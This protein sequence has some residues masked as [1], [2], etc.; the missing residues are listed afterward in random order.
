MKGTKSYHHKDLK[1]ALLQ[2]AV[3]LIQDE[4]MKG[5]SMRK[6]A[7]L[8]GVSH[9][10][11]YRHFASK[12]ELLATLML[13]GHM[14]LRA[15]LLATAAATSG[16]ARDKLLAMGRAYLDF[17]REQPEYISLMFS[18]EGM[19]AAMSVASRQAEFFAED[20]DSFGPLEEAVRACQA[21]GSLDPS[22]DPGALS[23]AV[24]SQVH[25]LALLRNEGM[26]RL[27]AAERGYTEADTL[28]AVF[29]VFSRWYGPAD[30]GC[31][32]ADPG[33]GPADPVAKNFL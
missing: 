7:A 12:E 16:R 19:A 32:P 15:A 5:F 21:E 9:T 33:C 26:I 30:P 31:G 22:S 10:A 4:G 8:A 23:F 14:R 18:G 1:Q 11:P 29:A 25:G 24:W 27:M 17:A 3:R 2:H 20:S 6:L 13:E 28:D